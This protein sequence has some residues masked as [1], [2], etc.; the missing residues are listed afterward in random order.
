VSGLS[1]MVGSE[2]LFL[3]RQR[4]L[5]KRTCPRIVG[6]LMWQAGKVVEGLGCRGMDGAMR[7]RETF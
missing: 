1:R 5:V 3:Y 6:L 4:A 2:R 7:P